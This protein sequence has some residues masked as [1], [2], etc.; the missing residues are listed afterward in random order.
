MNAV[1]ADAECRYGMIKKAIICLRKWMQKKKK[2]VFACCNQLFP[3]L[4]YFLTYI[5]GFMF[6]N[7]ST[8]TLFSVTEVR[9]CPENLK[10]LTFEC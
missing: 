4:I 7:V 9:W 8:V 6:L 10:C 5:R 2:L 1:N 3:N